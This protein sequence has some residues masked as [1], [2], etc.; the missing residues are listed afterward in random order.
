MRIMR[1]LAEA[2]NVIAEGEVQQLMNMHDAGLSEDEY[3]RVIR[4]KT[5]K[6]FEASARTR[7]TQSVWPEKYST[8]GVPWG[9]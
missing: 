7:S 9:K 3:V 2:T 4:S 6:L 5:A 1:T 8:C